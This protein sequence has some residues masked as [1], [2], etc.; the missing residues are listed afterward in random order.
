M[1]IRHM[2]GVR[3]RGGSHQD[4]ELIFRLQPKITIGRHPRLDVTIVGDDSVS[5]RHCEIEVVDGM[6]IV[7]DL[8]SKNGTRVHSFDAD[9]IHGEIKVPPNTLIFVG[10]TSIELFKPA[11]FEEE[12]EAPTLVMPPSHP[13]V[14]ASPSI[15]SPS[16]P[17]PRNPVVQ[18]IKAP[19]APRRPAP[20]IHR[21]DAYISDD[22]AAEG[23]PQDILLQ[24]E[25]RA[26]FRFLT[27]PDRGR[28][29]FLGQEIV[30][31]GR[32][33]D[34]HVVLH[35]SLVGEYQF[36]VR[37]QSSDYILRSLDPEHLTSINGEPLRPGKP[38]ASELPL[39]HGDIVTVGD[40]VIEFHVAGIDVRYADPMATVALPKPRFAFN[41]ELR[42]K[43]EL[44]VGRS[45][46]ADLIIPDH[47]VE[48][49][50]FRIEAQ[51]PGYR[52]YD[53]SAGGIWLNGRRITESDL[54]PGD[55]IEFGGFRLRVELGTLVCALEVHSPAPDI[56][57]FALDIDI[58]SPLRT[59]YRLPIDPAELELPAKDEAETPDRHAVRWQTPHDVQKSWRAPLVVA[60]GILGA[61]SVA[62]VSA[63]AIGGRSFID[64]QVSAAHQSN[65]FHTQR[66]ERN[67]ND[68]CQAC[69][70]QG[71]AS[72]D[73]CESCHLPS[74]HTL[75]PV[76]GGTETR[77]H[78]HLENNCL[79]CHNEHPPRN[80]ALIDGQR[81]ARCHVN[82][83][84]K[85]LA[86][87]PPPMFIEFASIP[88]DKSLLSNLRAD[89][90]EGWVLKDSKSPR[91]KALQK[92]H[93]NVRR[94]NGCHA[95][96]VG[97]AE[98]PEAA[99]R[100]EHGGPSAW[101]ACFHCHE[102]GLPWPKKEASKESYEAR[103]QTAALALASL[104]CANCHREHDDKKSWAPPLKPSPQRASQTSLITM[105]GAGL[106]G[107]LG[108]VLVG[109]RKSKTT[110]P[111]P[112]AQT[113]PSSKEPHK[114]Q[115]L[116]KRDAGKRH[117]EHKSPP[118]PKCD[119]ID[120][121]IARRLPRLSPALCTGS[122]TCVEV[123]P[124]G[125]LE[126]KDHKP[127]VVRPELCH[128]CQTCVE[129][130]GPG[131]LRMAE[132]GSPNPPAKFPNL[133]ANYQTSIT[134]KE[135]GVYIIGEAAG[136]PLVKNANNLGKWVV[137]HITHEGIQ[138]GAAASSG[139]DF[140]IVIIGA[141]PGGLS[142]ARTAESHG[143]SYIVLES[144]EDV[145]GSL[146]LFP[147]GKLVM[148]SPVGIQNI[149]PLWIEETTKEEMLQKW[150]EMLEKQPVN[151]QY[152]A[153]VKDVRYEEGSFVIETAEQS[154]RSLRVIVALGTRGMPRKLGKP[155]DE[156]T[157]VLYR[158]KDPE[159]FVN[160][161]IAVV[162]GGDS[163]LEAAAALAE[164]KNKPQAVMLMY[165][166]DGFH[167]AKPK[168]RQRVEALAEE[169][170][171]DIRL[172][173][174][175]VEVQETSIVLKTRDND[176]FE[177]PNDR[178]LCM[179]GSEKPIRWFEKL[180]VKIVERPFDW[181][182]GRTDQ[183]AFAHLAP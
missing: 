66:A 2:I 107:A 159:S 111:D 136:K 168:N 158:L 6:F 89:Y 152:K 62:G 85:L 119:G 91:H 129:K 97:T 126:M 105:C 120:R 57:R 104:D 135:G 163:A 172:E 149:G 131:A 29:V 32:A 99:D 174:N 90:G 162:G 100:Q 8:E 127:V 176:P 103:K 19:P 84:Q 121:G 156:L 11:A 54:K 183:P 86:V 161:N 70:A 10:D 155:G 21:T 169:G 26:R 93:Q 151:I 48:R 138:P 50:Q 72:A 47:R 75:R 42:M 41:G 74:E 87:G 148:D 61:L 115:G 12:T 52:I 4:E 180:G 128:E 179:L 142:A 94:C 150:R 166:G 173:T 14:P 133:D 82:R 46:E 178:V 78:S 88:E 145:G 71:R 153:R 79:A 83:H 109:Y 146:Q 92:A 73:A 53:L 76:S 30:I 65:T 137:D 117:P 154:Y 141:G 1:E 171:L 167:R 170:M 143:L 35:D 80:R 69:H 31:F 22:L 3:I 113:P 134:G 49:H 101:S 13:T 43:P 9:P 23:D 164:A 16:S 44:V 27:G 123:C 59:M 33:T 34:A 124:Y 175:V 132:P 139:A 67:L 68:G 17:S 39:G 160:E 125:V 96:N 95:I 110:K 28:Y 140:E 130:C 118:T 165:R 25:G 144:S 20:K 181:E 81:C 114:A 18:T 157:K 40:S 63:Q 5:T 116:Q 56:E 24:Q 37:A 36:D 55:E 77:G 64:K 102:A 177:V 15:V 60:V 112:E 51:F 45:P 7:R 106:L 98:N 38:N 182:P 58:A 122:A 147:A 108:L